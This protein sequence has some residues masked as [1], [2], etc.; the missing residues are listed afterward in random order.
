MSPTSS[1]I[2]KQIVS[3]STTRPTRNSHWTFNKFAR[4]KYLR[5]NLFAKTRTTY[6]QRF[7]ASFQNLLL[8]L[9]LINNTTM[10]SLNKMKC[11][12]LRLLSMSVYIDVW[13]DFWFLNCLKAVAGTLTTDDVEHVVFYTYARCRWWGCEIRIDYNNVMQ[14]F[15]YMLSVAVVFAATF[16]DR[17]LFSS[18]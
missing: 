14:V 8:Y 12:E 11:V 18:P 3:L 5:M 7:L 15:V 13:D 10:Q 2:K 9:L 1:E 6:F 16:S 17:L 4:L